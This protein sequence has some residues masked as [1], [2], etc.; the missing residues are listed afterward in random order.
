MPTQR[1]AQAGGSPTPEPAAGL[2]LPADP[3]TPVLAM[4]PQTGGQILIPRQ[5]LTPEQLLAAQE[6]DNYLRAGHHLAVINAPTET[7]GE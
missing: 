4:E 6:A 2:I 1:P 3:G 5:G 7:P